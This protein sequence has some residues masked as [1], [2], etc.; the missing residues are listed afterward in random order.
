MTMPFAAIGMMGDTTMPFLVVS[1]R[2]PGPAEV[3]SDRAEAELRSLIESILAGL[4]PREREV[5]ELSFRQAM[6]DDDLAIVLD[7]LEPGP[8]LGR[9][10]P[11]PGWKKPCTRCNI[12]LT[13]RD[14]CPAL[15]ELLADWDGQL[16]DQTWDLVSWHI[17]DCQTCAHHARGALRPAA[18]FRLLPLAPLPS[19]LRSRF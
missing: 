19:E 7:V 3:N 14:A 5:I 12:L 17:E 8:R 11:R 13:R 16:T 18:F 6:D 1:P 10:R 15:G 2:D 4:N 9:A